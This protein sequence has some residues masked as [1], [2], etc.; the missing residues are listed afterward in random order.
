MNWRSFPNDPIERFLADA[1]RAARRGE[2]GLALDLIV[3]ALDT[4][5]SDPA[6]LVR[7]HAIR[8][9]LPSA[10]P[11]VDTT[12]EPSAAAPS[13]IPAAEPET[14]GV[15]DGESLFSPLPPIIGLELGMLDDEDD[16]DLQ[17]AELTFEQ[18]V[19]GATPDISNQ[20][21]RR[22]RVVVRALWGLLALGLV[23]VIIIGTRPA[24]IDGVTSA[25]R[26]IYDPHARAEHLASKGRYEEV[27]GLLQ[28]RISEVQPGRRVEARLLLG[29]A[30][31]ETGREA[32][33]IHELERAVRTDTGWRNAL[34]AARLLVRADASRSAADAYL[35]AFERGA[36]ME[37]WPEIAEGQAVAGRAEQALYIRQLVERGQP[38]PS[39]PMDRPE[40]AP[41]EP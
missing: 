36:P 18:L 30:L 5:P 34:E 10:E 6:V 32:A 27:V 20:T 33:A 37:L 3:L 2:R 15:P 14:P 8:A 7:A 39:E 9:M 19:S 40:D 12:V 21:R 26:R 13:I 31:I 35:L 11:T 38:L 1:E 17:P 22:S 24:T 25:I 41:P 16:L 4:A 23:G 28:G 29:E